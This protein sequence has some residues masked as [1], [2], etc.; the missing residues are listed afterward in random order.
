MTHGCT[1]KLV[2]QVVQVVV[3]HH[4]DMGMVLKDN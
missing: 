1:T 3:H 2:V 4:L